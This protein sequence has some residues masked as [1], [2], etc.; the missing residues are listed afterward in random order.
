MKQ[1]FILLSFLTICFP[2][3]SQFTGGSGGGSD[4]AEIRTRTILSVENEQEKAFFEQIKISSQSNSFS[5][6]WTDK[7]S[8]RQI[9]IID[10]L[11]RVQKTVFI[12]EFQKAVSFSFNGTN[13]ARGVYFVRFRDDKDRFFSRKVV[14]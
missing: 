13:N 4:K 6:E 5:V 11:G 9:E 7:V 12:S 8:L 2:C 10:I 14:Y 1:L 3:Y